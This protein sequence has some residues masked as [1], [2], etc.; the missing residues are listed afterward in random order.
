MATGCSTACCRCANGRRCS[1]SGST[2]AGTRSRRRTPAAPGIAQRFGDVGLDLAE[3][4]AR[5]P[6]LVEGSAAGRWGSGG[7]W[8]ARGI[9]AR[10]PW[11]APR[12]SGSAGLLRARRRA[13]DWAWAGL[14]GRTDWR[15]P[16]DKRG[17][18]A[19]GDAVS[20]WTWRSPEQVGSVGV[21]RGAGPR[22][23]GTQRFGPL[24]WRFRPP[25]SRRRPIFRS[26]HAYPFCGLVD[27]A[28]IG[29]TVTL[30]GW[31]D[32]ARNMGQIVFIDLRDHEGHRAGGRRTRMPR[33]RRGAR[34]LPRQGGLRG[35]PAHH[36]HGAQ[37]PVGERQDQD[38]PGGSGGQTSS[39]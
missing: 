21:R 36:R 4:P 2:A 28:L 6:D 8:I 22:C 17:T 31:A 1:R 38:R 34:R 3:G 12:C 11:S 16:R 13:G 14:A 24:K 27:E 25:G 30:C 23:T 39:C 15:R 5:Q 29:Q 33:Q 18:R 35:L 37:A 26:V 32:V 9:P 20:G 19:T 7:H 10:S